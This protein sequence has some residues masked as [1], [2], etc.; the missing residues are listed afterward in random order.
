MQETPLITV[1]IPVFNDQPSLDACLH[2][3]ERQDIEPGTMEVVVIDNGS[4]PPILLQEEFRGFARLITCHKPGAYA[5]RNSGVKIAKGRILAF[6]DADCLP[7]A[8][9]LSAGLSRISALGEKFIIGGEV[10][11]TLPSKRTGTALYQQA[12]GFQQQENIEQKGFS[13]TANIFCTREQFDL[14]GPFDEHLLSGGDREWSWRAART[15]ISV[16]YDAQAWVSTLPRASLCAAIRQA[17]RVAAGRRHL[18]RR[19]IQQVTQ[20]GLAPHRSPLDALTWI[21]KY[22]G[23]TCWE[24]A[25]V[26]TAATVLKLVSWLEILRLTLGG[27]PERR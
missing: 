20:G 22:P 11:L 2:A 25:S 3:L 23:F 8:R 13:A 6:T 5:A 4:T 19:N 1:V 17:R 24:R 14:I 16:V 26:L 10:Q 18:A 15:G 7:S 12:T 21:L 27:K 9:W